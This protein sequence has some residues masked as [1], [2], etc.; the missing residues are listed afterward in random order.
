M[1]R[2]KRFYQ[3]LFGLDV[4]LDQEGNAILTEGLVLQDR[5]VWEG[6]LGKEIIPKNN[7]TLPSF[8]FFYTTNGSAMASYTL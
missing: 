4:V 2:S 5:A 8:D 3:E 1:E 6:V 7:T